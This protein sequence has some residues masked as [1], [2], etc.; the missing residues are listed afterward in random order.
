MKKLR[1]ARAGVLAATALSTMVLAPGVAAADDYAGQ[2][3]SDVTSALGDADMKAVIA[4]RS[5]DSLDDADCV[6]THSELAPWLKGD[7]FAPVTDTMLLYLN[8]GAGVA[9][10]KAPG[11]SK[12]SPEGRAAIAAAKEEA[13]QEQAQAAADQTKGKH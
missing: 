4:T 3:Y 8:C 6:V 10:A 12:A 13:E 9:S 7:D 2:K 5:G 11:N 1:A